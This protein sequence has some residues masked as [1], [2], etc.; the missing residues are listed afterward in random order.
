MMDVMSAATLLTP[1]FV[2]GVFMSFFIEMIDRSTNK[3]VV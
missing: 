2:V 3:H 1:L